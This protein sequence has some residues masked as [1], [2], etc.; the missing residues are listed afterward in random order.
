MYVHPTCPH[1]CRNLMAD[2]P[3]HLIEFATDTTRTIA[4][5]ML[6]GT[7]HRCSDIRFIFA[8]AGGTMPFITERMTWWAGVKKDLVAQMPNGPLHELRRFFYDTGF[9][10][11]A[12]ALSSLLQLV[13]VSQV[14]YGTDFPFR[15][16][17]ENVEGLKAY[18]FD[19]SDLRAIE[20]DKR[21]G[22]CRS[23][24]G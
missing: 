18:G 20:R 3:D 7:A 8:H 21:C 2:V 9:S 23:S 16:C 22:S 1:C 14:M 13:S 6:T 12:Y 24:H 11:N 15:G 4:S 10:A 17:V 19:A 5:L